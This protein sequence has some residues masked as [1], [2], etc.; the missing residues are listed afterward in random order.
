MGR[1]GHIVEKAI[2]TRP[3]V[4]TLTPFYPSYG[5][6]VSGC[7]IAETLEQL[8]A[9]GVAS[10]VFAVDSIYHPRRRSSRQYPSE[11]I[12][13]PRLPGNFGLAGAGAFLGARLLRRV[14]QLHR[15]SPVSVIHAHAALPC[16]HAAAFLSRR[17][18]IPFVVT[19]HGLDVFNRC[20]QNGIA[21]SWRRRASLRV[22]RSAAQVI[23]ISEKIRQLLCD[24][25]GTAVRAEVVYNGTDPGSFR[26]DG[27]DPDCFNPDCIDPDCV[28]PDR[29]DPDRMNH[30]SDTR[31]TA[32]ILVV[33]NLLAGKGHELV[34]KAVARL[35]DLY[36]HLQCRMI[37]AGADRDRFARLAGELG[38]NDRVHFPGRQRRRDVAKAMRA[39]T[40]FV[41]P[42]RYEGLGCV[43][44]EAMA[45]GKPAI[46]CQGQGIDEII[47]HGSNGWL[48]PVDGL[49][50]LVQGLKVLLGD[51]QLRA[52]IGRAARETIL[53]RLTLAHQ[54]RKLLRIYQEVAG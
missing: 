36:P 39:C 12:R 20:F 47:R 51:A 6:E 50:E 49:E 24:G 17:L 29:T 27:V 15:R 16:G 46:A 4:L 40:I 18:G 54:A 34:L 5:D 8:K 26:P 42:S 11:W 31:E 30:G 52:R 9:E 38:I 23:C 10:S 2:P 1:A 14:R 37:G 21:A 35:N 19:I 53:D 45:S 13:Y 7:F 44:L 28:N 25:A 32:E 41:L 22:Y 48:I 3:H 33:G 43:Y